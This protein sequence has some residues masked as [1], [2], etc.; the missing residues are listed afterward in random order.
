MCASEECKQCRKDNGLGP[1]EKKTEAP[2]EKKTEAPAE[3]KT[4]EPAEKK[5]EAPAEHPDIAVLRKTA[6]E[7]YNNQCY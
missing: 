3:K 5:T 7:D 1:L 6:M 4:E 2:A